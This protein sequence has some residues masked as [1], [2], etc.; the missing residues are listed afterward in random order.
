MQSAAAATYGV[1]TGG[2][3]G[4]EPV[5]GP[6]ALPPHL[7]PQPLLLATASSGLRAPHHAHRPSTD[8][9]MASMVRPKP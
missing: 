4:R 7:A 3:Q 6:H 1:L 2:G 5:S 9:L 8:A